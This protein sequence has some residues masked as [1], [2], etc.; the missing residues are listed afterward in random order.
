MRVSIEDEVKILDLEEKVPAL[1]LDT[2][3]NQNLF[4]TE[5]PRQSR[6][7][8]SMEARERKRTNKL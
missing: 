2:N 5:R 8:Q 3:L 6:L 4:H 1:N 7:R